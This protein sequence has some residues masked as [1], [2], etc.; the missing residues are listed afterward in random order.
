RG[1]HH[2]ISVRGI[3]GE[4]KGLYHPRQTRRCCA[5]KRRYLQHRTQDD[6]G[7]ARRVDGGWW[8]NCVFGCAAEMKSFWWWGATLTAAPGCLLSS[9]F[10][11]FREASLALR[12]RTSWSR[13]FARRVPGLCFSSIGNSTRDRLP[14]KWLRHI[15]LVAWPLQWKATIG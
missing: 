4:G 9:Q 12:I 15:G 2:G 8:E 7:C 13:T 11:G 3:S 1:I 14:W 10:S 5:A 6:Q